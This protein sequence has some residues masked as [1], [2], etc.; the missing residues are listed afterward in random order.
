MIPRL[1]ASVTVR[2]V[3]ALLTLSIV[4]FACATGNTSADV[5]RVRL[6]AKDAMFQSVDPRFSAKTIVSGIGSSLPPGQTPSIV[7][8]GW[9]IRQPPDAVQTLRFGG[10]VEAIML[11]EGWVLFRLNCDSMNAVYERA[12]SSGSTGA[13][14]A[15]ATLGITPTEVRLSVSVPVG[16]LPAGSSTGIPPAKPLSIVTCG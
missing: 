4:T 10:V 3:F 16:S 14:P 2:R 12:Y 6:V 5:A 8:G 7:I 15:E 13:F 1:V 9:Q 11:R